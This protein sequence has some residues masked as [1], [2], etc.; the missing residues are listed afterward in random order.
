MK[1]F[2][3]FINA[4]YKILPDGE[5]DSWKNKSDRRLITYQIK[6]NKGLLPTRKKEQKNP[7]VKYKKKYQNKLKR[8]KGNGEDV[9]S[10]VP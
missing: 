4:K 10:C 1:L 3:K 7:R 9:A 2:S 5:E 6:K 8:R